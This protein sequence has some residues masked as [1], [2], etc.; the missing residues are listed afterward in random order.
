MKPQTLLQHLLALLVRLVLALRYRVTIRGIDGI[1]PDDRPILFLPN[2]PALI[3]PVIVTSRLWAGFQ[4]RPLAD[5]AQVDRLFVRR[6][7][8]LLRVIVIPDLSL[9]GRERKQ[10]VRA[11]IN[12]VADALRRGDNVLLYPAGRLMRGP[13]EDLGANSAVAQ[14]VHGVDNVRIVMLRTTGLW[15]SSFSRANGIPSLTGNLGQILRAFLAGGLFF[16]PKREVLIEAVE[17]TDFPRSADKMTMNGYLEE[18]YNRRPQ[19]RI[20]VPL[21]WWQGQAREEPEPMRAEEKRDTSVVP[22]SVRALVLA[23]IRELAGIDQVRD[24]DHLARDL[25]M[26]S[27]VLVEF[28]VFLN[29]EFGVGADHLDGLQTVADC[30][31]AASGIMPES[32]FVALRPASRAWLQEL[33]E[34]GLSFGQ[35][36]TI[37]DL[38]LDQASRNPDQVIVADQHA[39][40]KTYRQ[41]ILA[42]LALL[43]AIRKMEG[44]RVG[45]MLPAS[46]G[47][48]ISYLAVMFAGREPVLVNWTTGSGQMR[49]CLQLAGVENVLTARA[50]TSRLTEQGVDLD[51]QPVH[52]V[53]LEELAAGISPLAKMRAALQS[54]LSWR[55]LR[56][57]RI[58]ETAAVLFTS[59]S[60]ANPK[61]VPL[62]HANILANGRDVIQVLGLRQSDR[63]LGILPVFHSLGLAGTVIMP[64]CTGLRT[65]FWPNPT[66]GRHLARMVDAFKL[67]TLISTPTFLGNIL[68]QAGQGELNTL[69]LIFTG[70]EKCPAG[71]FGRLEQQAPGAILCEG[72]GVTECSPVISVN[73]PEHSVPETIGPLLPSMRAVLLHPETGEEVQAG[74]AGRLLVRGPNVFGGYLGDAPSPFIRHGGKE[75][76]DTGDLVVRR[77]DNILVF[78][79]RLKRFVKIGGEMISLPAIEDVLQQAFC[80][81]ASEPQLAVLASGG[82]RPELILVTL[83]ELGREQVNQA[84]RRGGLSPL[85]NIRRVIHVDEIPVL[86]TGKTDYRRLSGQMEKAA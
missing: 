20:R 69:R 68:H 13:K 17:A 83:L 48:V 30:L 72:Y 32:S 62:S 22:D 29:T 60:E 71:L 67:T 42:I 9:G 50:F 55:R 49:H 66:E 79:G 46:V 21:F 36:Q 5:E 27:L 51:Q 34:A 18:F 54:R 26:D 45:I 14:I 7:A 6:L 81:N 56:R 58:T 39:G 35:G 19:P 10:E 52:W 4:P 44:R 75:W 85:Y 57:A 80:E 1:K 47:A 59:G 2:H 38:F 28:G 33:P 31:L 77:P 86:G 63:L 23:K 3:D 8:A 16:M 74:V 82:Q 41:L 76:Y 43:P 11:G 37:A 84:L 78:A 61:G 73:D 65:V 24:E 64:L 25:G 70:A 40:E 53:F 15:G 12:R